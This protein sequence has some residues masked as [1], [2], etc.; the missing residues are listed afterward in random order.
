MKFRLHE[1][2]IDELNDLVE[3]GE[4]DE[5]M[6]VCEL[7]QIKELSKVADTICRK[8]HV[9]LI[10]VAG[11][12]SAGK[13]TTAKR[14]CTQLRVDFR[15]AIQ[16]STDDYFVGDARN[17]KNPDGTFDYETVEAVDM[18]RLARDLNAL[19]AG[20][21]IHPRRFDFL[22][23]E[24]F[25]A[26]Q[27]LALPKGGYIVLEGIHALNPRLTENVP[28]ASKF[29]VFI[30]PKS[31]LTIFAETKLSPMSGRLIRRMVRDNQFRKMSPLDTLDMW[32]KVLEGEDKWLNPFRGNADVEFDS[33]LL[34]ELSVL[35]NYAA[36]LIELVRRRRPDDKKAFLFSELF[37]AIL[38]TS[39]NSV[40]GDSILREI[41]G[42]SQ[43][44]Y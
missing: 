26:E 14:L 23:H 43:L 37:Q 32:P 4:I 20:E 33:G 29:R 18:E 38:S 34:Y 12:S 42:G 8:K 10:L 15:S 2:T 36:G 11:G 7:R 3:S 35:R 39:P 17:P 21:T 27:T 40:P 19:M 13:T 1:L 44:Q 22:L 5:F 41:I 28:D 6:R 24:G 30:E 16:I 25:D 31:Q 9:R